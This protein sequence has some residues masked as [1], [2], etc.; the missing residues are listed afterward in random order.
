MDWEFW[1]EG[2]DEEVPA[3]SGKFDTL[4]E[5]SVVPFLM[6]KKL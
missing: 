5:F 4:E 6:A 1:S 3:A 2:L